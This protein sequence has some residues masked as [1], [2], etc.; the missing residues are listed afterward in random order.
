MSKHNKKSS[1]NKEDNQILRKNN[2]LKK[3]YLKRKTQFLL[4]GNNQRNIN[5]LKE[6]KRNNKLKHR[7]KDCKK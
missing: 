1:N 6:N 7:K 4:P 3:Q 2:S 5:K